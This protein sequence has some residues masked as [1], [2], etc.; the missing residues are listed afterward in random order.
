[1]DI[2]FCKNVNKGMIQL[3]E[4]ETTHCIR[5]L[6]HRIGDHVAVVNGDGD[7]YETEIV[8]I[9]KKN[10][11]LSIINHI[12]AYKKRP[13]K[14]HI[15]I[16]PMKQIDRFEWFLEKATEMGID[17]IIP[18]ICKRSERTNIRMDRLQQQLITTM[19][20]S[21]QA[22]LPVLTEPVAYPH[23]LNKSL[24]EQYAGCDCFFGYC[25][26]DIQKTLNSRYTKG[27]DVLILIGPA[28]D[29]DEKE[30][31]LAFAKGLIPFSLG[32]NRL[33]TETAGMMS[34][35]WIHVLNSEG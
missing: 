31:A 33:R 20:Q 15:A 9:G 12:S 1:M 6:R 23:F 19:K 11:T 13:Y 22:Y 25:E 2:F 28:G 7:Y 26:E 14:L 8:E 21:Q 32:S 16:A 27:K 3:D 10:A 35:A 30:I 34:C 5:S 17:T 29:F 4:T 24:Q 18:L